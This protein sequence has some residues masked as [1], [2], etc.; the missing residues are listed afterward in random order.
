MVNDPQNSRQ[1]LDLTSFS[2][3]TGAPV[4]WRIS[5]APVPYPDAVAAM[6]KSTQGVV[7]GAK[8]S[9][10]AGQALTE[11]DSVTKNLARL[12]LVAGGGLIGLIL[13][14]NLAIAVMIR[15]LD[16]GPQI[17]DVGPRTETSPIGFVV[18]LLLTIAAISASVAVQYRTR[19]VRR[20]GCT[21]GCSPAKRRA[22]TTT[23]G[24]T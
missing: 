8:L 13:L 20:F 21:T 12:A 5:D 11:I 2:A 1:D 9:N 16:D 14:L 17:V 18:A 4:E 19:S 15:T 23:I 6:E 22:Q 3:A 24:W 7:E 10:A